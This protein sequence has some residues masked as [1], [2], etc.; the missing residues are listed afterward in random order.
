MLIIQKLYL[1]EFLG[2][3]TVLVFCISLIFSL[4]G[5][6]DKLDD[7]MPH[8]PEILQLLLY[9]SLTIPRIIQYLLPVVTLLSSLFIFTQA[10]RRKEIIAIKAASGKLKRVL[11]PFVALGIVLSL[12]GLIL[13]E[14]VVPVTSKKLHHLKNRI[15]K[16]DRGYA[17]KEGTL[18]LRG[19]DGSIVRIGLFLPEKNVAQAVSI[20]RFDGGELKERVDAERA[21][22]EGDRWKLTNLRIYDIVNGKI[23]TVAESYSKAVESPTLFEEEMWKSEEM[24]LP[25]L[26]SFQRRLNETGFKNVKIDV[27]ISSR[28]SYPLINFFMMLLGISLSLG[29]TITDRLSHA[30]TRNSQKDAPGGSGIIAAGLGLLISALYWLG[31]SFFLSLGYAGVIPAYAAPWIIPVIFSAASIM[32]YRQIPE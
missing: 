4:I 19:K 21:V 10:I 8:N 3:M 5:L 27:D 31:Y 17:F 29:G 32:L 20:F 18:Y 25:E 30:L 14:V 16:K 2:V 22:W 6:V 26:V 23:E 28:V 15:T 9:A 24:T 13:G 12:A 1:R 11:I 7:F